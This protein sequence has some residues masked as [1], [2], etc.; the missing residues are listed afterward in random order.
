MKNV[1][2]LSLLIVFSLN[3]YG[4]DLVYQNIREGKSAIIDAN[5]ESEIEKLYSDTPAIN[6]L[7]KIISDQSI[8]EC[9]TKVVSKIKIDLKLKTLDDVRLAILGLRLNDAI[10]DVATN[11][12]LT[13]NNLNKDL[14]G[15]PITINKLSQEEDRKVLEILKLNS[16]TLRN[17]DYCIE[18]SYRNLVAIL[19]KESPKF[20]KALKHINKLGLRNDMLS[21]S[22]YKIFEKMRIGKVVDW[23][24]TLS[25]YHQSLKEL[26]MRFP[27]RTKES[28]SFIT[29]RSQGKNQHKKSLRQEI[30]EKYN[31]DQIRQIANM[32]KALKDRLSSNDISINIT[33]ANQQVEIISLTPMEKF[34]FILKLLRKELF[35]L[36]NSSQMLGHNTKY[37]DIITASYEVGYLK[38]SE[39]RQLASLEEIW[40]PKLSAKEKV[41]KWGERFGGLA[42]V[43]LPPPYGYVSMMAIMLIDQQANQASHPSD[44]EINIF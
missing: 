7:K 6:V 4:Q 28:S 18:D 11:I 19:I 24:L 21:E 35:T 38:S 37:I 12:L 8:N 23:P 13:A 3:V 17:K 36:N 26:E 43:L 2:S 44:L 27:G 5:E 31:S 42:S 41:I 1:L 39:L 40:N 10:D 33:Y 14:T 29:D 25:F 30:Y 20:E 15:L 9:A 22:E 32:A 34:R 16:K